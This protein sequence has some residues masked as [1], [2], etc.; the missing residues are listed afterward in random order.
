VAGQR[1]IYKEDVLNGLPAV[2]FDATDDG[3][4]TPLVL[5]LPFTI[6]VVYNRRGGVAWRRALQGSTDWLVGPFGGSHQYYNGALVV[7]PAVVQYQ[8][9]YA[10]VRCATTINQLF[11]NGVYY[12][13]NTNNGAPGTLYLGRGGA[14]ADVLDGDIVEV[15]A[16]S[17]RHGRGDQA[18]VQAYL[19]ARN[20][21]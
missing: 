2:R 10:T 19:A 21:L 5:A 13:I 11:V 3:L 12:G 18:R 4:A 1:P 17:T 15:L 9:V 6:Y 7:G 14:T 16:Y 8:F 20:A